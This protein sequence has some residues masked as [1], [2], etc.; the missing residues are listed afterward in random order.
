MDSEGMLGP[1]SNKVHSLL[2]TAM[3][4]EV[5]ST[6]TVSRHDNGSSQEVG[7]APPTKNIGYG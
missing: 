5:D 7:Q 2:L 3:K 4:E 1:S 6:L